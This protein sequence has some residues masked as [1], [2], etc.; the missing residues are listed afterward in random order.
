MMS[1]QP[2]VS[3][4]EYLTNNSPS[5]TLNEVGGN[6]YGNQKLDSEAI[7]WIYFRKS[8]KASLF[9]LMVSDKINLLV[10]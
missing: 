3:F 5:V 4:S 6:P 9:M 1:D 10:M 7:Q 2:G 8:N